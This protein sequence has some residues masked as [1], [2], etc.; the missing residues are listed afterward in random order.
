VLLG[1]VPQQS[2][3]KR[4]VCFCQELFYVFERS[5]LIKKDENISA[6]KMSFGHGKNKPICGAEHLK[7]LKNVAF[8]SQQTLNFCAW[9]VRE[10]F[11]L[12]MFRELTQTPCNFYVSPPRGAGRR[13]I[14][15]WPRRVF[16]S[17]NR[18]P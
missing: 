5:D 8:F 13:E 15:C 9:G 11:V 1:L 18:P 7:A 12:H 6:I 16:G 14:A 10:G 3:T 2:N 4:G 17:L